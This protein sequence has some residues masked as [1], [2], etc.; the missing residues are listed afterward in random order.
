M[1]KEIAEIENQI[2]ALQAR[3]DE[4]VQQEKTVASK[5]VDKI[6]VQHKDGA[7]VGTCDTYSDAYELMQADAKRRTDEAIAQ[8]R[9]K[10]IKIVAAQVPTSD[11]VLTTAK[12]WADADA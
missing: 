3:K 4:L 8:C 12:V 1:K 7:L 5:F 11:Y 2:A 6:M 9:A 10:H